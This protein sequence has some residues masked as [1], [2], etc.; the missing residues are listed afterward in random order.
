MLVERFQK[1]TCTCCGQEQSVAKGTPLLEIEQRLRAKDKQLWWGGSGWSVREAKKGTLQWACR[2]CLKERRAIAANPEV[3]IFCDYSPYFA[4]Y[5]VTLRCGDCGE[6]FIFSA[7]EQ[8]YWYE[9]LK[10]WVQSR[11]K[12]CAACRRARRERKQQR[13]K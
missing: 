8:K 2:F 7:K 5:D 4:Y 10:F 9:D 11:P 13:E 12:Q 3:Q 6:Q 1:I